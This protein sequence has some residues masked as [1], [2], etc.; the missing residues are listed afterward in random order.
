MPPTTISRRDHASGLAD[1][2]ARQVLDLAARTA[3][4][5]GAPALSEQFRLSLEA[6]ETDGVTHLLAYA[7]TPAL[8]GYAQCRSAADAEPESAELFVAPSARRRGVG[9]ALLAALPSGARVWSHGGDPDG[10]A[11]FAAAR[12]LRPVRS[13]HLLGRSLRSGPAWPEPRLP[14]G[15][16]VRSFEPGRDEDAWL[17]ANAAAFASHPEQ[18]SWDRHDLQ[19]RMSQPWFDPAGLI[20]VVPAAAPDDVAA[21]HWTK[22][23][24]PDGSR[25]EVYIL[26]VSPEHQ[27][28]GLGR[29]ATVLGLEHLRERGLDDVVLYVDEDNPVALHTYRTLGFQGL[30]VHRQYSR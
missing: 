18:G 11:A 25:G 23:D 14:Q 8:V 26:G 21:F 2:E 3:A 12:G 6:R 17:R 22:V 16:A 15:Y 19:L 4:A 20:V 1:T 28:R 29:V 27:G 10:A 7:G 13:L 24:P 30:E 9:S 5:D